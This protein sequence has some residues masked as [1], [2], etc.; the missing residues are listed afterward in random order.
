MAIK[1]NI[2]RNLIIY[3]R[4]QNLLMQVKINKEHYKSKR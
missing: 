2:E 3:L 4:I 1:K